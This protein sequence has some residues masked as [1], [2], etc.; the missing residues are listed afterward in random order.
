MSSATNTVAG[1]RT[2]R[3]ADRLSS[4]GLGELQS[5][6]PSMPRGRRQASGGRRDHGLREVVVHRWLA[7]T[8]KERI[9]TADVLSALP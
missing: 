1:R 5:R 2:S 6:S 4:L 9:A 3:S 8:Y 7:D